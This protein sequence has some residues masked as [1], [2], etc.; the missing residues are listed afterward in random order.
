M[1]TGEGNFPHHPILQLSTHPLDVLQF[2]LIQFWY[3]LPVINIRSPKLRAQSCK[4]P[5][6][7]RQQS[8]VPGASD[9][10]AINRFPW[11]PP[12]IWYFARMPHGTQ[13]NSLLTR[14]LVYYKRLQLRNSQM[15]E[16]HR[17][18]YGASQGRGAFDALSRCATFQALQVFTKLEALQTLR[19][20]FL[21]R[22]Y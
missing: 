3:Y 13:E 17:T 12:W 6:H 22:L 4:L 19:L 5:P 9:W 7:F 10:L 18:R 15:E 20:G 2:N 8:Q 14:S 1:G 11:Y 16:M 21:W